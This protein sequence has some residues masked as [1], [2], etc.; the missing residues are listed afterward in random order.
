[1][2]PFG[3]EKNHVNKWMK[4]TLLNPISKIVNQMLYCDFGLQLFD[5]DAI[6]L[7]LRTCIS[8]VV[9]CLKTLFC[10]GS[11]HLL[12]ILWINVIHVL[13]HPIENNL[14]NYYLWMAMA[15]A[16]AANHQDNVQTNLN[17][18]NKV[19]SD[20]YAISIQPIQVHNVFC[21]IDSISRKRS[22]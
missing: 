21:T 8:W 16:T 20:L 9:Y 7:R 4:I 3:V 2:K 18:N 14:I 5:I 11:C 12:A 13:I 1:M 17:I 22:P 10:V 6:L 15:M 19:N